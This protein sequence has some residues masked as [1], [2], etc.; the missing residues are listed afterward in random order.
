MTGR[1]RNNYNN[2]KKPI[3]KENKNLRNRWDDSSIYEVEAILNK[4]LF[5]G[6]I[7]YLIQWKGYGLSENSWEP[8]ENIES[9][10]PGKRSAEFI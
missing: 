10:T 3:P 8:R 6:K 2:R 9:V 7:Q 4:R 5:K 1:R